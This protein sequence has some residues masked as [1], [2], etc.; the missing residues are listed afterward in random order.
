MTP[1]S[2]EHSSN[3]IPLAEKYYPFSPYHYGAGNPNRYFDINGKEIHEYIGATNVTNNY[4]KSYI[5]QF[6]D[7]TELYLFAHGTPYGKSIIITSTDSKTDKIY[8]N[9]N[10]GEF[11]DFLA[12]EYKTF[13]ESETIVLVSCNAGKG[14]GSFAE[15]LSQNIPSKNIIAPS[16]RV[17]INQSLKSE[18]KGSKN[19]QWKT[20]KNGEVKNR[21]KGDW[22][23]KKSSENADS[24]KHN[25][26]IDL[27]NHIT[28]FFK[29]EK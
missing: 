24:K 18:I 10:M 9:K 3:K 27:M 11:V 6:N 5:N 26:I 1:S 4:I 8:S 22:L 14:N 13:N 23:D 12:K 17:N 28:D 21:E 16:G 29:W 20:F 7:G 2:L 19:P 15:M 25:F